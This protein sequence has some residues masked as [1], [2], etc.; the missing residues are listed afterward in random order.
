M[1]KRL[2]LPP[3]SHASRPVPV[4]P[5]NM[6]RPAI[7][8]P[9]SQQGHVQFLRRNF[10]SNELKPSRN[11]PAPPLSLCISLHAPH[12]DHVAFPTVR[13]M[14]QSQALRRQALR[15]TARRGGLP[16]RVTVSL[17]SL[18][19]THPPLLPLILSPSLHLLL[20]LFSSSPPSVSPSPA[21]TLERFPSC[22]PHS[23]FSSFSSSSS[24]SFPPGQRRTTTLGTKLTTTR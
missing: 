19:L 15:G 12:P 4:V 6:P 23:T 11:H 3:Q 16:F 2:Q 13:P 10:S 5:Q 18:P 17:Q 8:P 9:P 7:P 20:F 22:L 1:L 24:P 21:Q 14:S